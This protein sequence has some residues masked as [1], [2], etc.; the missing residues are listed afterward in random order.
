M[1]QTLN[2]HTEYTVYLTD[3]GI[4]SD[5]DSSSVTRHTQYKPTHLGAATEY[6]VIHTPDGATEYTDHGIS[7][8]TDSSSVT[9]N[10]QYKPTH[11]GAVMEYAVIHTPDGAPEYTVCTYLI[12]P[13]NTP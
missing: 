12:Q 6:P 5:T 13:R 1:I 9:R 10:T 4:S 2:G 11:L 7:S 8:D 3:H